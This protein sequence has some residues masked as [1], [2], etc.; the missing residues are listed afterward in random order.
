M[1]WTKQQQ[2]QC[3]HIQQTTAIVQTKQQHN[4][5]FGIQRWRWDQHWHDPDL[6]PVE[7]VLN[8]EHGDDCQDLIAASQVHWHDQHLGQHRLQGKL[9]HLRITQVNT[10]L[11]WSNLFIFSFQFEKYQIQANWKQHF[12]ETSC[13]T[14]PDVS[15]NC[16]H[17]DK[18]SKRKTKATHTLL[19]SLVRRPSSSSA[20][21]AWSCS[22]AE[23]SVCI[24]GASM[25]SKAK[26][27]LMPMAFK[28]STVDARL[29]RWISGT[30]VANIS[31]L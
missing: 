31:S 1:I 10:V 23:I 25:K 15:D 2:L 3:I 17:T 29:V 4:N 19:P 21:R 26:R 7:D 27:S 6:G 28:L 22:M 30:F 12:R 11:F 13:T 18:E 8:T 24:G 5:N 16:S 14:S 9:C 20:L